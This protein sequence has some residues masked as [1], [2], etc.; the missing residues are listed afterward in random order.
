MTVFGRRSE[1][2][3]IAFVEEFRDSI[4]RLLKQWSEAYS[5]ALGCTI[6]LGD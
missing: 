2:K 6:E 1:K 5:F 3:Q 4:Q